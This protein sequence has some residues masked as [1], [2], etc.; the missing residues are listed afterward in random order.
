MQISPGSHVTPSHGMLCQ[1]GAV[2]ASVESA[3]S[4]LEPEH[5]HVIIAAGVAADPQAAS[6]VQ[7][8]QAAA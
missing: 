5:S 6:V 2:S 7:T 4:S 8:M 1:S 3:T